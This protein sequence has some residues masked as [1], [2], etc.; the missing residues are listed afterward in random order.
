MTGR[1]IYFTEN[2]I[3]WILISM[4]QR[5]TFEGNEEG[6]KAAKTISAKTE[7]ALDYIEYRAT[8]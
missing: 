6:C 2:E 7:Q 4:Q 8:K 1:A 3:K 5:E